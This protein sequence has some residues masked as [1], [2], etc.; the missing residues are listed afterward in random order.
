[1]N[2]SFAGMY[3]SNR[4]ELHIWFTS[5]NFT[6]FSQLSTGVYWCTSF[7]SVTRPNCSSQFWI[8]KKQLVAKEGS[9]MQWPCFSCNNLPSLNKPTLLAIDLSET[10]FSYPKSSLTGLAKFRFALTTRLPK[11]EKKN[12]KLIHMKYLREKN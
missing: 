8:R 4:C 5:I 2:W 3:Y 9:C 1:M 6:N 10:T 11:N 12:W 7:R